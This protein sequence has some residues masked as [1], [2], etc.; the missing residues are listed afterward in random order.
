MDELDFLN[1][2]PPGT[3]L[4]SYE[5]TRI[6]GKGGFGITY[7]TR[8]TAFEERVA[9][10]K[11]YFPVELALRDQGHT[12]AKSSQHQRLFERGKQRFLEEAQTL[13]RFQ[14]PNIIQVTDFF[15]AN[16]TAYLVMVYEDGTP[17]DDVYR[18]LWRR[19]H[20][21]DEAV[22]L[23]L[24]LLLL[25]G[26]D[27]LHHG[28]I[29]H[30]DIK[31]SNIFLRNSDDSP[32]LLDFG[33]ARQS[34]GVQTKTL[35]A[36]VSPGYAPFEQ[37]YSRSASQGP[38]S[39][40]YAMGAVLYHGVSGKAPAEATLRS[41]AMLRGDRDPMVSAVELGRGRYSE[42]LL[43]AIDW[44][45]ALLERQRPQ[46]CAAFSAALQDGG[47]AVSRGGEAPLVSASAFEVHE[48]HPSAQRTGP[49]SAPVEEGQSEGAD[50]MHGGV[51]PTSPLQDLKG[52]KVNK[53][54]PVGSAPA[55]RLG[56][57]RGGR[58]ALPMPKLYPRRSLPTGKTW[59]SVAAVG[60]MMILGSLV[61]W[62][63][64]QPASPNKTAKGVKL[65]TPVAGASTSSSPK[66]VELKHQRA[67]AMERLA[68]EFALLQRSRDEVTARLQA[69]R[70]KMASTQGQL[71]GTKGAEARL[72]LAQKWYAQGEQVG[73]LMDLDRRLATLW[74]GPDGITALVATRKQVEA[75][76][77]SDGQEVVQSKLDA[78]TAKLAPLKASAN[79]LAAL[80]ESDHQALAQSLAGAWSLE[81]SCQRTSQWTIQGDRLV[82]NDFFPL[83]GSLAL[84]RPVRGQS[85]QW[86]L[87]LDGPG[88]ILTVGE[89]PDESRAICSATR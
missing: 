21:P 58:G 89:S 74:E 57:G 48:P 3:R 85:T 55:P 37:Y 49:P 44:S 60:A 77:A 46:V 61:W 17:L 4:Q 53:A 18:R 39:D 29:I 19:G 26:L 62:G 15:E 80:V 13:A 64:R 83:Q 73:R 6:L 38:W 30:R 42:G 88:Q 23:R 5:V 34:M 40:I 70:A 36:V 75:A 25:E 28:G 41:G 52:N 50:I 76:F 47:V 35:T 31:P 24:A 14:H 56:A 86:I 32:V 71:Q 84:D 72:P 16:G 67:F 87:R 11:E 54:I 51:L 43:K 22:L 10:I 1:V 81:A 27:A 8:H 59:F 69:A 33:S 45:L 12:R 82:V 7:L 9:A 66:E 63:Q 68:A 78:L 2:L 79:G 20:G 65:A